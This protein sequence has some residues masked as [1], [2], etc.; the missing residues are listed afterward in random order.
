V[1]NGEE[2]LLTVEQKFRMDRIIKMLEVRILANFDF[3]VC[4]VSSLA[5]QRVLR[6]S[7][8]HP[9]YTVLVDEVGQL[10]Q[11]QFLL[12]FTLAPKRVVVAG[13]HKQL[14]PL[15]S[16]FSASMAGLSN[17]LMEWVELSGY[18]V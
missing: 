6:S 9:I 17:S 12:L 7:K 16:S 18:C 3:L 5:D 13:D 14:S 4:T 10:T 2:Y 11:P 8:R 1:Q 15:I